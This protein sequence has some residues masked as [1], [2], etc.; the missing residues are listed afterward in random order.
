MQHINNIS[1]KIN[2]IERL[3]K[4]HKR[5]A[6]LDTESE[7]AD[8]LTSQRALIIRLELAGVDPTFSES[9]IVFGDEFTLFEY[10]VHLN[11]ILNIMNI[12]KDASH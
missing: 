12:M 1:T 3:I 6:L 8:F 5:Y 11:N 7:K 4:A 10:S 2:L 9:Y